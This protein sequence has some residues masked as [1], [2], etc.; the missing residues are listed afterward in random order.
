MRHKH[1]APRALVVDSASVHG[2]TA[3]TNPE[4]LELVAEHIF[5]PSGLGHGLFKKID[6]LKNLLYT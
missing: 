1:Q 4:D 6:C 5:M 3:L 2:P